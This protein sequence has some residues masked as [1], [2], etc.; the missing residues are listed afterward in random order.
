MH[1]KEKAL[2]AKNNPTNLERALVKR[3]SYG[4]RKLAALRKQNPKPPYADSV[5][6]AAKYGEER[7]LEALLSSNDSL[8]DT[9]RTEYIN[10]T[11]ESTGRSALHYLCY[12]AET[13][14]V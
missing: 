5:L 11:E 8:N 6:A 1:M 9:Q 4:E 2:M 7:I 12:S 3:I 14:M 13:D 10:E